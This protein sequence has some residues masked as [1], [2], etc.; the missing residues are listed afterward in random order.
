MKFSNVLLFSTFALA[1]PKAP[2]VEE[3]VPSI[4][5]VERTPFEIEERGDSVVGAVLG[6]VN[7]VVKATEDNIAAIH[8]LVDGVTGAVD[9][10]IEAAVRANLNAIAAALQQAASTI[11][12]ST[13]NV[14]GGIIGAASGLTQQQ[15][16]SLIQAVNGALDAINQLQV[17]I[18]AQATDLTPELVQALQSEIRA[19]QNAISPFIGPLVRFARAVQLFSARIGV[20][21]RGLQ[22]VT[23]QLTSVVT[24]LLKSLGLDLLIPGL[25]QWLERS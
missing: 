20:T 21:V 18:D 10:D 11:K 9:V 14:F 16:N 2:V 24:N 17:I 5:L 7:S 19:I 23:Q 15:I 6:A 3:R 1:A 8:D 22:G 13:T 25:F 4:E 12:T